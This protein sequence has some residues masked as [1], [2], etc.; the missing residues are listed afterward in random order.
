VTQN[1]VNYRV[2]VLLDPRRISA[3][4]VVD[5]HP[6]MG[7]KRGLTVTVIVG[8]TTRE[9]QALDLDTLIF[10]NRH[11]V[12]IGVS[13]LFL[14]IEVVSRHDRFHPVLKME[15]LVLISRAMD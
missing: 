11:K 5:V 12:R 8:F 9:A 13:A 4:K 10:R 3:E 2:V 7:P 15:L 6:F 1:Q 14:V